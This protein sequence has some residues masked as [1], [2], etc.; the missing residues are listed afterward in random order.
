[1]KSKDQTKAGQKKLKKR[2]ELLK[3][4]NEKSGTAGSVDAAKAR[5]A[6]TTG[7]SNQDEYSEKL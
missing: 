5:A 2:M 3:A 1:M 7:A 6:A 4:Q